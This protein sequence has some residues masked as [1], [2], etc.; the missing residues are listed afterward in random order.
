MRPLLSAAA[1]AAVLLLLLPLA[2]GQRLRG[3]SYQLDCG[4]A[5]SSTD[6][7]GLR[8][9]PDGPYVS[10]GSARPLSVQGLL[11]PALASLRAFP[12]RTN[13]KFCYALPVDPNRR[14]LLRPTF[15]YGPTSTAP[16]VFDLIVDGTF[17]TAVDTAD[18]VLAGS[19]S[20]YEAVF[21]ARGR[22][23][24]FCLGVNPDY[25]KSGPFINALQVIQLHDSVYNATDFTGSAMGLIAR[26]KFGSTGDVERYPDDSFDRYWQPFPDRKHA[27]SST[28]NVTSA[29]FWN[30][31]PPDVFNTALVA[32]QNS[33][34]VLQWPPI[35]LQNGSYYVSL[36][37]ADTLANSSRTLDVNINDYQFYEGTVTSA[38]LSVFAT[39]WILSGLTRVIL[40]SKSVLP[41]LINAGEVFGIFPIGRLTITRDALAMESMKR[42]LQN[43]PDD[44]IGDPCMPHGY[45]WTGVTCDEGQNIRVISLNF[46]SMGISGSLSPDIANLTALT[47]ISFA[48][49]SLSG[50]IPDFINLGKLQRLHLNDNKLNGT[51][52]QTLGTIQP[53][54]ELFLQ[55]N[56]L[57]GAVPQ[58]LLNKTGLTS[59]FCP[60]NQFTQPQC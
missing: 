51:I 45:A 34:L 21:P 25:T 8:W 42:S 52:A 41:P 49:N 9:D 2:A 32:E 3:F 18:D 7:R 57:G 30:L 22:N 28:H 50:T 11:D 24:T 31:P 19:A 55:G 56:D 54:R 33:P 59:K 26:T 14:Y 43:I 4:A 35:S 60:G 58:N 48:N 29:D 17:W 5:S 39:Q 44:W 47:D 36:Y 20:H 6:S 15:F 23:L 40:T 46:S 12:Y 13:A 27:V 37:F 16:P 10:A 53:L 38:G 1:A